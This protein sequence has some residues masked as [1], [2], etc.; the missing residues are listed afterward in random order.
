LD[1]EILRGIFGN[2][3]EL[4]QKRDFKQK[5]SPPCVF[6]NSGARDK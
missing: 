5:P 6:A 1:E 4:V 2:D 3:I